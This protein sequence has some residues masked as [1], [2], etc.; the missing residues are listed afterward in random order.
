MKKFFLFFLISAAVA[1]NSFAGSEITGTTSVNFLKISPFARAA[2]MA[3]AY[4]GI[5]EGTYGMFYNPAGISHVLAYDLH[6]THVSWFQ[7]INYEYIAL[8]FPF[9]LMESA[10]LGASFS[11]LSGGRMQQTTALP[12]SSYGYLNSGLNWD[13]FTVKSFNPFDYSFALAYA[14]SVK[15]Y[16]SAGVRIRFNSQNISDFSGSNLT[17]D[18]GMLYKM[19][20]N[21][22]LLG[23]GVTINNLG[24][25]LKMENAGAEPPK[26]LHLGVSDKLDVPGGVLT[27]GAQFNLHVDYDFQYMFGVEYMVFDMLYLRGGYKFGGFNQP[28][29]G[30]GIKLGGFGLDYAFEGYDELGVTHRFSMSYVWGTPPLKLKVKQKVFSPNGDGYKDF[31]EFEAIYQSKEKVLSSDVE[32]FGYD[33]EIPLA[34]AQIDSVKNSAS[35]YGTGELI[36][37]DGI[38][39]AKA[40]AVYRQGKSISNTET[41]E[42]DNT[43][44]VVFMTAEPKLIKPGQQ[45]ALI[46]PSII[47][48]SAEDKNGIDKWQLSVWDID[49][50]VFY[51]IS[52]RGAP[53]EKYRWDGK[54]TGGEYVVTGQIYYYAMTAWDKLGNK[55]QTEPQSQVVLLKEIKLTY[56]SDA[57]FDRGKAD[58]KISAYSALKDMKKV[59]EKYEESEILV[60]GF[61]DGTGSESLEM[62]LKRANAVKFF[63]VNLLGIEES[64][65]RTEGNGDMFPLADNSTEEGRTKNRRVEVTIKS[66]IYK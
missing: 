51:S 40:N 21:K 7:N 22:N 61:T 13:S 55:A 42:V 41:F 63:M 30:C 65:I 6:L 23:F 58:V 53:P 35:W 60:S 9:P 44:P 33:T 27:A 19:E 28:T 16:L 10:K 34:T 18:I 50:K 66:T 46:I 29:A 38:Y 25:E 64:R 5:S 24:S 4:E 47:S 43:P 31:V 3:G 32:I 39:T 2:A 17:A 11:Y 26:I 12:E 1:I 8:V 20:I 37:P 59:L 62:S 14:M 49:K 15:E 48:M 56:S 52:G 36:I 45:D 57:L 54:G